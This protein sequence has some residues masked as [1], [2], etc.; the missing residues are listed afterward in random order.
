MA[1]RP[2]RRGWSYGLAN[3]LFCDRT[4]NTARYLVARRTGFF[5]ILPHRVVGSTAVVCF[6]LFN[7]HSYQYC[8]SREKVYFGFELQ[9][10]FP[11]QVLTGFG[12]ATC[13]ALSA[14]GKRYTGECAHLPRVDSL[15]RDHYLKTLAHACRGD[16]V[17]ELQRDFGALLRKAAVCEGVGKFVGLANAEQK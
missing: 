3:R 2:L 6:D 7:R 5:R 8:V 1:G 16:Q 15:A 17:F 14:A 9:S 10:S 13:G 12:S 11:K 4:R